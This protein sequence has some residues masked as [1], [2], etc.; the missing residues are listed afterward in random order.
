MTNTQWYT[1]S[2]RPQGT[3]SLF[4]SWQTLTHTQNPAQLPAGRRPL[5]PEVGGGS[6]FPSADNFF[7]L[8][9]SSVR[10]RG[11]SQHEPATREDELMTTVAATPTATPRITAARVGLV[12]SASTTLFLLF[13]A[14]IHILNI[15]PVVEATRD[16]GYPAGSA[17]A[18]GV[19]E[20]ACLALYVVPRTSVL[21]A[22][23]LTGYLGGAVS[24]HFRVESPLLSTTLF[25]V[26]LGIAL[27]A[28]LY[29]RDAKLRA[30][31]LPTR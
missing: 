25:P 1:E 14:V 31:V 8:D 2:R 17:V 29:L 4:V 19:I 16:L 9:N 30:A 13:D 18:I 6:S 23:L 15:G 26:Y 24:A 28:G 11:F 3:N 5:F 20:L 22:L 21:G 7:C 27:W 12:L 10:M